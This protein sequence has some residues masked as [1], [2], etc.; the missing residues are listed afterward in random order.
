VRSA[1]RNIIIAPSLP[2]TFTSAAG[3][4]D[5]IASISLAY[6]RRLMIHESTSTAHHGPEWGRGGAASG[7]SAADVD[8][9]NKGR[10][11]N[12]QI[13]ALKGRRS[14]TDCHCR[15]CQN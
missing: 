2:L 5:A 8:G 15:S 10:R 4:A 14:V 6:R 9:R 3:A 13:S 7:R 12:I 1:L 11:L